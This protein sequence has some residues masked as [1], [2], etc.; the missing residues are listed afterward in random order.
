MV[1]LPREPQRP[2]LL[3]LYAK[4]VLRN[5]TIPLTPTLHLTPADQ[6]NADSFKFSEALGS[7]LPLNFANKVT[8]VAMKPF[9]HSLATVTELRAELL[10]L[11]MKSNSREQKDGLRYIYRVEVMKMSPEV[12]S[13]GLKLAAQ[14]PARHPGPSITSDALRA[15]NATSKHDP[16]QIPLPA[17]SS[18]NIPPNL[19]ICVNHNHIENTPNTQNCVIPT[20]QSLRSPEVI[21]NSSKY[22]QFK[23]TDLR[24]MLKP[25][26]C[27]VRGTCKSELVRLC[28]EF[29]PEIGKQ[30]YFKKDESTT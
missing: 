9:D 24:K 23:V 27:I 26:P 11:G 22:N 16:V 25:F 12:A 17:S 13:A 2:K 20:N 28:D 1:P 30:K 3:G 18:S 6:L 10:R 15:N 4:H 14:L 8:D 19:N 7:D 21:R 29:Q 5:G